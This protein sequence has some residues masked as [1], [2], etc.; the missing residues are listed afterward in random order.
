MSPIPGSLEQ[1]REPWV[2]PV[3]CQGSEHHE[4]LVSPPLIKVR[5]QG[6][7]YGEA[8]FWYCTG[9]ARPRQSLG[10]AK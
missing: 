1:G 6:G 9:V 2:S 7:V 3:L 4:A 10:G 5:I 8:M